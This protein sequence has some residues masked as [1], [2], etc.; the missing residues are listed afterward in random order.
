MCCHAEKVE[1]EAI[2]STSLKSGATA[3]EEFAIQQGVHPVTDFAA[4]LG[5]PSAEDESAEEFSA[6]LREWRRETAGSVRA[7]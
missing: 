2:Q 3:F 5:R 1:L 4:L 6:M 7:K